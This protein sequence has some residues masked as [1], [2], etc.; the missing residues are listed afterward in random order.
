MFINILI[1]WFEIIGIVDTNSEIDEWLLIAWILETWIGD[2]CRYTTSCCKFESALYKYLCFQRLY[3]FKPPRTTIKFLREELENNKFSEKHFSLLALK[4]Y[5]RRLSY[6]F[7]YIS[8]FY[9]C[10]III[11]CSSLLGI[12]LFC[13]TL[14]S[15]VGWIQPNK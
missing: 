5:K 1:R 14:Q 12:G 3:C 6:I 10:F 7:D 4:Y 13:D 9:D 2:W 15:P 11:R 8:D